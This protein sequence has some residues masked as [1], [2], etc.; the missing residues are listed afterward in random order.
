MYRVMIFFSP[1]ITLHL[2]CISMLCYAM[3][4]YVVFNLLVC[5][6]F[7]NHNNHVLLWEKLG[8]IFF[9]LKIQYHEFTG[10][11][12]YKGIGL[13]VAIKWAVPFVSQGETAVF[14]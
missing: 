12:K 2:V 5:E 10:C 8:H 11:S 3:L 14:I 13:L 1:T 7:I 9:L 6:M 4:C